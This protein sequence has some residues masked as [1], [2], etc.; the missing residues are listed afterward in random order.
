MKMALPYC[1]DRVLRTLFEVLSFC[2]NFTSRES[3]DTLD[4]KNT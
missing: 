4:S 1:A 2:M 3:P